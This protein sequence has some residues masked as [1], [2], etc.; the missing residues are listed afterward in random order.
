MGNVPPNIRRTG[1]DSPIAAT[2][3]GSLEKVASSAP[4]GPSDG[5]VSQTISHGR[6]PR[7]AKTT[8]IRPRRRNH[9]RAFSPIVARTS[10]LMMALS[11]PET[12]SKTERPAGQ[13]DQQPVHTPGTVLLH[14]HIIQ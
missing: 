9:L 7:T 5:V 6:S 2:T 14:L 13:N 11:M 3:A 4:R 12:I 10:A 8:M 1:A